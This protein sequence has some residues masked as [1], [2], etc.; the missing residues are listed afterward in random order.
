MLRHIIFAEVIGAATEGGRDRVVMGTR[1]QFS[2]E[3]KTEAVKPVNE[4]GVSITLAAHSV[5]ASS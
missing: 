5:R 2:P 4:C 3:F 1:R